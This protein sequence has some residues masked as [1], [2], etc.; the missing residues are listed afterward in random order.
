MSKTTNERVR[1][2]P[3]ARMRNAARRAQNPPMR[4][5]Q[6]PL[7][8]PHTAG[9]E[10]GYGRPPMHSRFQPGAS[11]NPRGR[12]KPLKPR[13]VMKQ[14]RD[15]YLREVTVHDGLKTRRVPA[16]LLLVQKQLNDAIRGDRRAA[17]AAYKI[18]GDC[19]ALKFVEKLDVDLG[20]LTDE[21]REHCYK[22]LELMRKAGVILSEPD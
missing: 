21:E 11:G 8:D 12:P 9:Y 19:G 15:V 3:E 1:I 4:G 17:N 2:A 5:P 18:A 6:E 13:N 7:G 14:I 22:A 20:L 10:V 16:I